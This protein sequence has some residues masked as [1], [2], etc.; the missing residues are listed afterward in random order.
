MTIPSNY[1]NHT[2]HQNYLNLSVNV[3]NVEMLGSNLQSKVRKTFFFK[4]MNFSKRRQPAVGGAK[5]KSKQFSVALNIFYSTHRRLDWYPYSFWHPN[6]DFS[7]APIILWR[8]MLPSAALNTFPA[9]NAPPPIFGCSYYIM[10]PNTAFG[11]V[12]YFPISPRRVSLRHHPKT[13]PRQ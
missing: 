12:E 8:R 9:A 3:W 2:Y 4:W 6:V 7:A 10:A 13:A 11:G 1:V 5:N